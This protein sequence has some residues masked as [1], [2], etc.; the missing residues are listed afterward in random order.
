MFIA[1][2]N[3][4]GSLAWAK[5]SGGI[6]HDRGNGI[7]SYIDGSSIVTGSFSDTAVFGEVGNQINL[8]SVGS[9][10]MFI[11]K[12]NGDGSLAWA[13]RAGGTGDYQGNGI[14][15]YTD[16]SSIVTGWLSGTATF[17]EGG[18]QVSLVSSGFGGDI[19]IAKYNGDG[20]L[21]WAKRAGG[22]G[23]DQGKG[24]A[25]YI[26]GSSIVTGW[27]SGTAVFGEGG[28]QINLVNSDFGGDMFVAKY[29]EDGSLV[30]AKRAGGN[31]LFDNQV[32]EGITSYTD[33]SSVIVG[34]FS[35]TT[36]FGEGGNQVN[37]VATGNN[38]VFIAKYNGDGSLAW[39]KKSGGANSDYGNGI[40][41]Y[42]DG[43]TIITGYFSGIITFGEAESQVDLVS[44]GFEDIFIAKYNGDGSLVWTKR[45]GGTD[46]DGGN[47]IASYTDGSSI[48]TGRFD[49][50]AIFGESANQVSLV[51]DGGYDNFIV[52]YNSNGTLE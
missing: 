8:V 49:G 34:Y 2:Y 7:A 6:G 51:S 39:A 3:G 28:N 29:N 33:G 1:K 36:I 37:L 41:S 12:Y 35:G 20:S 11:A 21:V 27:F 18:N 13:K 10:D 19:F 22:I 52:K 25:S 4:D 23:N 44:S 32:G 40:A 9:S 26:D 38:D 31:L 45:A 15:S 14:A 17:G 47:A 42:S 48:V 46:Y 16:G 50:T 43:T 24:I 5:R 30:W